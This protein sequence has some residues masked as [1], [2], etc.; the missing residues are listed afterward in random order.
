MA[1][2]EGLPLEAIYE[3]VASPAFLT[4]VS[5]MVEL[6]HWGDPGTERLGRGRLAG[7]DRTC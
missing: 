6:T 7:V 5:S 3:R 1:A 4:S 2:A